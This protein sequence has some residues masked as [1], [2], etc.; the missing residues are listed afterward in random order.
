VNSAFN[1][2]LAFSLQFTVWRVSPQPPDR[3]RIETNNNLECFTLPW[4]LMLEAI[5]AV[6]KLT[7]DGGYWRDDEV[8]SNDW[9][10]RRMRSELESN[11]D[12]I[13]L[14]RRKGVSGIVGEEV[15]IALE[16][17]PSVVRAVRAVACEA[18]EAKA[19]TRCGKLILG[20]M[21]GDGDGSGQKFAHVECVRNE[22]SP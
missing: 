6:E 14:A 12:T 19:C 17:A 22:V 21:I 15:T 11:N 4:R 5:I 20:T 9:I 2:E 10:A 16:Y 1:Q 13:W 7:I 3:I 8:I 18:Y